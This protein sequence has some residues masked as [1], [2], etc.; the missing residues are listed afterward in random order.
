MNVSVVI[1]V[2]NGERFLAEAI[3]SALAQ[4]YHPMEVIAINDGSTDG[5]EAIL[6]R[7]ADRITVLQ[8][9]NLGV[10]AARNAGVS[11]SHGA[12]VAFLDQD[13]TWD[14]CKLEVQMTHASQRDDVIHCNV[15]VVDESGSI[16]RHS[17]TKPSQTGSPTFSELV[18]FYPICMS[19]TLV[20]RDA[21]YRVGGFDPLNR[22]GTDDRQLWLALGATGGRFRY[23]DEVLASQRR[24]GGNASLDFVRMARGGVY[25]LEKTRAK[26]PGAFARLPA[27]AIRRRKAH[28]WFEAAWGLYNR[29]K[30]AG[31]AR[32]FWLSVWYYP[33][34][35]KSWMYAAATSLPFRQF[36]VPRLRGW[37][38]RW[39]DPWG[40]NGKQLP[41]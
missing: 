30:Y 37:I 35:L 24:H 23:V 1:P 40:N 18:A 14:P 41:A 32:Y 13:D 3:E 31:A 12:W 20:R 22:F 29:A 21:L 7:Y 26:H 6:A 25:A 33:R 9:H 5:S 19:T 28:I 8:Q 15:R 2:Y 11:K 39:K 16:L 38:K 27:G 4:T 17:R 10:A 34:S 36:L